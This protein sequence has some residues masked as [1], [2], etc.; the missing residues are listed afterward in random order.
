LTFLAIDP[1]NDTG[2]CLMSEGRELVD[3]G[4]GDPPVA[5]VGHRVVI[6]RPQ[7]YQGRSSRVNP[8]DLITLAIGVGR[9]KE[10]F[11]SRGCSVEEI[12]PHTWK[13]TVDPEI[14][15][16]RVWAAL[17][18]REQ[19]RVAEVLTPLARAPFSEATLTAGKRH[20]VLDAIG[21]ARW[22]LHRTRA[23]VF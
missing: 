11:I 10:R 9:Y 4:L 5:F 3:A 6:E 18:P 14:L 7:V 23:G 1:G 17:D 19:A 12:L 22:S 2:W 16:R 8:N 20:N 21:L 13:G 15:C